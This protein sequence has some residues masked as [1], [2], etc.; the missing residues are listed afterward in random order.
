M[1][2]IKNP[3]IKKSVLDFTSSAQG[4]FEVSQIIYENSVL[5]NAVELMDFDDELIQ[6]IIC[7]HCGTV[8][9]QSGNWVRFRKSGDFILLTPDFERFEQ[10]DWSENEFSPPDFYDKFSHNRKAGTPY[11][12]LKTYENLRKS[13]PNFPSFEEIKDLKMREAVRIFQQSAPFQLF[14]EP[15][16]VSFNSAKRKLVVGASE[17][18]ANEHLQTIEAVLRENYENDSATLIRKRLPIEEVIYIFL[19]ADEFIDW[20]ALLK[21]G[22]DYF[23]M[24]N[25]NF[26]IEKS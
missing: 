21:N 5:M 22:E 10:D 6:L 18:D 7:D 23:L 13:F 14:G 9:C 17:G 2:H 24:I 19:D 25:D 4:H 20:Q 26:V 15:P 11:F 3:E 16:E 1:W 8:G 12:D